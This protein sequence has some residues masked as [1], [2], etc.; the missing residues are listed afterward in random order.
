MALGKSFTV[1]KMSKRF[2]RFKWVLFR[3][4]RL[5]TIQTP[6]SWGTERTRKWETGNFATGIVQVPYGDGN[7]YL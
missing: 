1:I 5:V 3:I 7:K 4:G 2:V 6:L